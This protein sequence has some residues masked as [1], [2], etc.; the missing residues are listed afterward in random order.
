MNVRSTSQMA[1]LP[2]ARPEKALPR[3][4]LRDQVRTEALQTADRYGENLGTIAGGTL[5]TLSLVGGLYAGVL[6]GAAVGALFGGG[7]GPMVAAVGSSGALDF[8]ATSFHAAGVATKVGMVVGGLATAAGAW[9]VGERLGRLAGTY[10][11]RGAGYAVGAAQGGIHHWRGIPS[12]LPAPAE[13][14]IDKPNVKLSRPLQVVATAI[15]GVGV[16]SG[17]IGGALVGAGL[18]A[19]GQ[20]GAGLLA[21]NLTLE[22]VKGAAGLGALVGAGSLGVAGAVG[23]WQFVKGV[24]AAIDGSETAQRWLFTSNQEEKLARSSLELDQLRQRLETREAGLSDTER[25]R[26]EQLAGREQH[27]DRLGDE[28]RYKREH[29]EEL[30]AHESQGLATRERTELDALGSQLAGERARNEERNARYEAAR[31]DLDRTV[32]ERGRVLVEELRA[33]REQDLKVVREGVAE[34]TR[35]LD[36][37]KSDPEAAFQ[38][39]VRQ[40]FATVVGEIEETRARTRTVEEDKDRLKNQASEDAARSTQLQADIAQA[41]RETDLA[42]IEV[43]R[44]RETGGAPSA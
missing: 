5:G 27:I 1:T 35:G 2:A 18:L 7:F 4:E 37:L 3:E 10:P 13:E 16:V 34:K 40:E 44:R 12:P 11:G 31:A 41:R 32:A 43:R 28:A 30:V 24:R 22:A 14:S 6:G 23:G 42:K 8:I 36:Q 15:S 39:L 17:L 29:R 21:Q 9:T 26:G 20:L 25:Q 19:A 38:A 33:G